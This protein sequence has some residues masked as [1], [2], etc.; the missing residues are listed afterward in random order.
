MS[1]ASRR[2]FLCAPMTK[3]LRHPLKMVKICRQQVI[4]NGFQ[5]EKHLVLRDN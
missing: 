1:M 4:F 3:P 5:I 2:T